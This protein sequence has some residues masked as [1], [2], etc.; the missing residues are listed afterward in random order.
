[1]PYLM[2]GS[3]RRSRFLRNRKGPG[4]AARPL[5][6]LTLGVAYGTSVNVSLIVPAVATPGHVGAEAPGPVV[7]V[8]V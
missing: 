8:I 3:A 7:T 1:M 4:T 6:M 5:V 2:Q